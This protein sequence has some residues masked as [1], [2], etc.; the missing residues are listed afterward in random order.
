MSMTL[1]RSYFV[2]R[3]KAVGLKEHKDAFNLDNNP[4]TYIDYS[5]HVL[6]GPFSGVKLN[7]S[8]QEI[9]CNVL[10]TFWVKGYRNPIDGFDRAVTKSEELLKEVLKNSNRLGQCLKNVVFVDSSYE[11]LTDDN[12]NAIK[13]SM[14]FTA[15][16]SLEIT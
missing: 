11:A 14:T 13:V 7:Q 4:S 9:E 10:L 16:T 6:S 1:V 15:F 3:A 12:D 2:D 5:F 8:D